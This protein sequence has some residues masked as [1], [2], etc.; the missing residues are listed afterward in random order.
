MNAITGFT[1]QQ[2][3]HKHSLE[4]LQMLE[5]HIDFMDSIDSVCDM[6]CGEGLDIEWWATRTID[7][8]DG[9]TPLNIKC[10]GIDLTETI[11]IADKYDNIKYQQRDF[12]ELS[13]DQYDVIWSHN[14]FQYAL[15][16]LDTLKCW[17]RMITNGG[18]LALFIP[19][20]TNIQYN[21]Q[22]F[23]VP[24][25]HYFNYT[26][27]TLMYMLAVN[28]FDCSDGFLEKSMSDH[29]IKAVVYKSDIEPMDPRTTSWYTLAEKGLLPKTAVDSITA[30]GY[31]RQR[32][33]ILSWLNGS[34]TWYGRE[35]M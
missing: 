16:P 18:M 27:P 10:T 24:N 26:L 13:I 20:T 31:L 25:Y 3:S 17:N 35:W 30:H 5:D 4:T 28:G 33:L 21:R 32:D 7:N 23:E 6:G 8:D 29:W 34:A 12:E 9:V 2:E 22:A 15:R 1:S 11:S 14:S 19:Q